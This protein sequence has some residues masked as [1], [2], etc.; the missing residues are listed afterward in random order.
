MNTETL[1]ND[2]RSFTAWFAEFLRSELAPYPGRGVLVARMVISATITMIMVMTFRIPNGATGPLYAFLIARD[3]LLTT[4]RSARNVLIAFALCAFFVPVGARMFGSVPITHF[5]WEAASIF[6]IFFLIRTLDNYSVAS[7]IGLMATSALAVW[8]LPGPTEHNVEYTLWQ[9]V[10]PAVGAAVTIAVEVVFYA[11][12]HEDELLRG[13]SDRLLLIEQ[14]LLGYT[15]HSAIPRTLNRRLTQAT[16]IGVG[17]LRRIA[18]RAN[19]TPTHRAQMNAVVSLVGRSV[20]FAAALAHTT[21]SLSVEDLPSATQLAA[22]IAHMRRRLA[23]SSRNQNLPDQN[24][25]D[26]DLQSQLLRSHDSLDTDSDRPAGSAT[27]PVAKL[28]LL[29]ELEEMFSLIPRVLS[30]TESLDAYDA[31][32]ERALPQS[33][34]FVRDAFH[35]P[36]HLRY[37][38]GGC[39]AG[40]L[41]YVLYVSLSWPGLATSVTTCVLTALSN[42]GAS[43][44]KQ[45]LRLAGAVIGGFVFGMGAQIVVLPW[46]NSI[47]GFTLLFVAVSTVAA[48]IATSSARLSYCGLQIA[49]AFYLIN[50]NDFH[51]Q[52]SLAIARD[53]ALGVLLGISMMW[54]VFER[55][56]PRTATDAM[57]DTFIE[58][59]RLLAQFS[60]LALPHPNPQSIARVRR[61]RTTISNHFANV[62]A[63]A[64]AVPFEIGAARPQ[65]MAARNHIR[66]WQAMLRTYFLLELAL[67]Q[68]TAFSTAETLSE[69]DALRL[70]D[71]DALCA[72]RLED[73]A[74]RLDAQRRELPAPASD[75]HLSEWPEW[76]THE[77]TGKSGALPLAR[78]IFQL[79]TRVADEMQTSQLFAVEDEAAG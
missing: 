65:H 11:L 57:L 55:L 24:L 36:E 53:R 39:L 1:R 75:T 43:R 12:F 30:G 49:L 22:Q 9:I 50:V 17:G 7:A 18:T 21:Q 59:L 16:M 26:H 42:I 28:P 78:E 20:D 23:A 32:T 15:E 3:S 74:A 60:T 29:R 62:N 48:W 34:I 25:P 45:I 66:R 31:F 35:N 63:Q 52:L 79:L 2:N 70:R 58:N 5:L 54:V 41:C 27:A 10:S 47:A 51:I 4:A 72:R 14:L 38:L 40:M 67:L 73:L 61:L 37:A 44:Q 64:D 56:H 46:L 8:Y 76:L 6:L 19:A 33:R 69:E 71:F 13:L 68:Y 77:S